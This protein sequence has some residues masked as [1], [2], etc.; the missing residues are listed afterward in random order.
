L[1]CGEKLNLG[2]ILG[3]LLGA[4]YSTRDEDF[5]QQQEIAPWLADDRGGVARCATLLDRA[6]GNANEARTN[7][8]CPVDTQEHQI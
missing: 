7:Q 8:A 6:A 3:L 2:I 4:L 5:S 1:K